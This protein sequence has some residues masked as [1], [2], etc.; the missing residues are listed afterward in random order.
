MEK[1]LLTQFSTNRY[2]I[3]KWP[4]TIF[5]PE[6]GPKPHAYR[7]WLIFWA[8]PCNFQRKHVTCILFVYHFFK[9][10]IESVESTCKLL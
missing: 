4:K 6:A 7:N 3:L 9:L 8:G 1:L 2:P 5:N 10:I